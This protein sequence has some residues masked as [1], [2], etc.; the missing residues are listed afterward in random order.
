MEIAL[1]AKV[2]LDTMTSELLAILWSSSKKVMLFFG[3]E[4]ISSA[5]GSPVSWKKEGT[6]IL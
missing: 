2:A 4:R 5:E 1:P 3:S 6:Q